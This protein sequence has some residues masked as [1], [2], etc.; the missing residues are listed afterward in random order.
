MLKRFITLAPGVNVM[1]LFSSSQ[2]ASAL[3]LASIFSLVQYYQFMPGA[4]SKGEHK[5]R[6]Y[7]QIKAKLERLPCTWIGLFALFISDE[8]KKVL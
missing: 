8:E 3:S 4:Y 2:Y 6:P 7:P 1:K 5:L